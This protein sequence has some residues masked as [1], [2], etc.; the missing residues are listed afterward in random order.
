MVMGGCKRRWQAIKE[1]ISKRL[2]EKPHLKQKECKLIS[3]S[4]LV[5]I[6]LCYMN[7]IIL[8][9]TRFVLHINCPV[10]TVFQNY[11]KPTFCRVKVHLQY[12]REDSRN[13]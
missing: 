1:N 9:L 6:Q 12:F 7:T 2:K 11:S 13:S 8:P 10:F 3:C 4:K 5:M